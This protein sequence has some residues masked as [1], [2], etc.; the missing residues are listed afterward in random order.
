MSRSIIFFLTFFPFIFLLQSCA[1]SNVERKAANNIDGAYQNSS[2]ATK[3]VVIGGA[4]GAAV[5]GLT[6][7]V[8]VLPG[9]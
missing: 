8:G 3:G 7:G 6:S 5:G 9:I 1:S 2:Q 4:T